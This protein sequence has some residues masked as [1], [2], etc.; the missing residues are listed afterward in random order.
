M[1]ESR[2]DR[3]ATDTTGGADPAAADR[4]A[5]GPTVDRLLATAAG[6][7]RAG[8]LAE[9]EELLRQALSLE[10]DHPAALVHL[11]MIAFETGH[12]DQARALMQRAIDRDPGL[13]AAHVNLGRVLLA[14]GHLDDAIASVERGV[15]LEA[16]SADAHNH[17]G[18][19]LKLAGRTD[20]AL[21][22][23]E[24]ALA[25][26]PHS[27]E[28]HN[29]LGNL[30]RDR[31]ELGLAVDH[32]RA[33]LRERPDLAEAHNNLGNA[34]L[35]RGETGA[36]VACY[37]EALR[38]RSDY[39]DAH[40]NLANALRH[41]GHTDEALASLR[42]ATRIDP[43][44]A[45]RLKER[46]LPLLCGGRLKEGWREYEW[47]S[48]V[49][50]LGPFTEKVWRG[51]SPEGKTLL[52]W[53]EQGIGDQI[54]FASIL[55][56]VIGRAGH[57]IV[58]CDRRLQPLFAR[59]FPQA[60]VHGIEKTAGPLE[61]SV[62]DTDQGWLSACPPVDFFILMGGLPRYFRTS[63]ADFPTRNPF[64]VADPDRVRFWRR[65]LLALGPGPK[66]GVSW[67]SID[68]AGVRYHEHPPLIC[69]QPLLS[70]EGINFISLQATA[71]EAEF[72]AFAKHFG[73]T[74]HHWDD[75]D[76]KDDLDEAAALTAACDAVVATQTNVAEVAG[77][78]GVRTWR[79]APGSWRRDWTCLGTP[80]RPW[81]PS[82]TALF[83]RCADEQTRAFHEVAESLVALGHAARAPRR[84]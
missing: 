31:G 81:F 77:G 59:S 47:R 66:V 28:V 2:R 69:W 67:R 37:R 49:L 42:R 12:L 43:G 63:L 65:R 9:A 80:R 33:A 60:T 5:T 7:Q 20:E 1:T 39:A 26:D 14:D 32:F 48:S 83:S 76:L 84:K 45:R 74:V 61:D 55:P 29:N 16:S 70:R 54:L 23:Y 73:A 50:S 58:T 13:F 51:E 36:A 75:I 8:R 68:I 72:A 53:W 52:V 17:L 22:S 62:R 18:A 38:H 11:G 15:A 78:L 71:E 3:V 34:H 82:M 40:F 6:H 46:S 44:L 19:A 25:L 79:V 35:D 27:A 21:A 10:S 41:E 24:R 30:L 64:L 56:D 57:C 4:G